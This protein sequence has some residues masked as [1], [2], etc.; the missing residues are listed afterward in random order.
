ME[1]W[2]KCESEPNHDSVSVVHEQCFVEKKARGKITEE[3]KFFI[4][5]VQILRNLY[6]HH[7]VTQ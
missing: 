6:M 1:K 2:I 5:F 4:I 7:A 3:F